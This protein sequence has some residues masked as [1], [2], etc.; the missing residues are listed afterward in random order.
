[1]IDPTD[2]LR[3]RLD[4][5]HGTAPDPTLDLFRAL[6]RVAAGRPYDA[7]IN[8]ACNLLINAVR[9]SS[10][11]WRRAEAAFDEAFGRSKQLLKEHYDAGGRKKGIF[12]FDQV[13]VAP[14]VIDPDHKP[15]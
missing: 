3:N 13:V 6:A 14:H 5:L 8:A 2:P 12:P 9:Q 1:M 11:D 10:P 15:H 7:V 4:P